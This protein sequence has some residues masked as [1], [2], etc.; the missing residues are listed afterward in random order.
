MCL[1]TCYIDKPCFS[2]TRLILRRRTTQVRTIER[3]LTVP[4]QVSRVHTQQK[5]NPAADAI[6]SFGGARGESVTPVHDARHNQ[7]TYLN[8]DVT[9]I[10]CVF[11][12]AL[13]RRNL[14]GSRNTDFF[15]MEIGTYGE[16][17]CP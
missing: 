11:L 2:R 14:R 9:I 13:V 4:A 10:T 7:E 1:E 12:V 17:K 6:E 3:E 8:L 16:R 15:Q 5:S